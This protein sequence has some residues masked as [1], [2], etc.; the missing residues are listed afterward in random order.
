MKVTASTQ[1]YAVIGDPVRHSLSPV[2]HNGWFE[3]HGLDA[4]YIAL[5]L[6]SDDP[7]GAI[8]ALGQFGLKGANITVPFK[9]AAALAAEAGLA[10]ANVLSWNDARGMTAA[11]TDGL[12]F[13]HA[14]SEAAP[15]WRLRVK[16]VLIVGA[17]GAGLG[18]AQALAP[19]VEKVHIAN[20]SFERA[21]A[22]A[23][24]IA[25]G[26]SLRWDDLD[27]GFGGA[28]LIVQAT[29]L[30][31]DG[32]PAPD[33][34]VAL[35]RSGALVADIVYRPL[36]TSLLAAARARGLTTM[37]GLGMLIHQGALAFE[38]WHGI[39]PDTTKARARLLAA[40]SP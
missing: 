16:R 8:R 20:R 30:G 27:R 34:P 19:Y 10:A 29:T 37:D 39:K 31:M 13:V 4:V 2:M 32:H 22:A 12:G 7:I 15:D 33:W 26:R 40:L 24:T 18:I 25:N 35:C 38:L 23:A 28:D 3:D 9:E 6:K 14:L 17:G 21:E 36:E 1:V 5:P 11:N